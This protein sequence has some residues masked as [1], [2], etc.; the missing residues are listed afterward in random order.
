MVVRT[1]QVSA[2]VLIMSAVFFGVI[3]IMAIWGVI[4]NGGDVAW[5]SV[6]SLAVIG[7]SAL[8]VNVGAQIY[9]GKVK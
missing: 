1:R 6:A 8:V 3:S 7:L 9:E 2:W 4:A 5:K